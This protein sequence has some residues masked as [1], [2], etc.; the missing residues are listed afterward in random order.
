MSGADRVRRLAEIARSRR[1]VDERKERVASPSDL[2][3]LRKRTTGPS[4]IERSE[5]R[6]RVVLLAPADHPVTRRWAETYAA[7]GIE[8]YGISLANQRDP[9]PSRPR[10][11]TAYLPVLGTSTR[12]PA[13]P[14]GIARLRTL[15]DQARPDVVHVPLAAAPGTYAVLGALADRHPLVVSAPAPVAEARSGP[16]A[17]GRMA[18]LILRRAAAVVPLEGTDGEDPDIWDRNATRM[19]DVYA[20]LGPRAK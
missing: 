17:Q 11:R 7:R 10:V 18:A 16:S 12:S 5:R 3:R 8:V 15:I 2:K 13:S 9:G 6:M 4:P 1:P 14:L 19:L 20:G